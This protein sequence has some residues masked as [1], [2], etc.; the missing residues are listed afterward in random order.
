MCLSYWDLDCYLPLAVSRDMEVCGINTIYISSCWAHDIFDMWTLCLQLIKAIY[1]YIVKIQNSFI[2]PQWFV[3]DQIYQTILHITTTFGY[4]SKLKARNNFKIN[5]SQ[6][7]YITGFHKTQITSTI[8]WSSTI[9]A[10][11]L[12]IDHYPALQMHFRLRTWVL[13]AFWTTNLTPGNHPP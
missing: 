11:F 7:K 1:M 2:L 4:Q 5:P 8:N 10:I 12:N 9:D 3:Q 13:S 6:S